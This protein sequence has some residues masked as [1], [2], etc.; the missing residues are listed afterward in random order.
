VEELARPRL[1]AL[2][3]VLVLALAAAPAAG[4]AD[5]RVDSLVR[6]DG[7]TVIRYVAGTG[8]DNEIQMRV[9]AEELDPYKRQAGIVED[10]GVDF[11]DIGADGITPL[12]PL[13]NPQGT[14]VGCDVV[15]TK[16]EIQVTLGDGDDMISPKYD[17]A[18]R[19]RAIVK[20]GPGADILSVFG[21]V[22]T[23]IDFS[24]GTGA[25]AIDYFNRPN[26]PYSFTDDGLAN[27][28]FGFDRIQRDVE[29]W[30]GG[31]GNDSF[32]FTGAGRH[33]VFGAG[34][35]DTMVSG[36][37]SD[38][39]DGGYG[40][41]P[42][43]ADARSNDAVTYAGR[44][45][46]VTVTLDGLPDDGAPGEA[47]E[48]LPTVEHVIGTAHPDTLVGPAHAPDDRPYRLD[49]GA[50]AD[51]LSGGDGADLIDAGADDDV[52]VSLGGR[53][54]AIRCGTGF[55]VLVADA[56][57]LSRD[58]EQVVHS[59]VTAAA[60]Q[61]GTAVKA[62]LAVPAPRSTVTATLTSGTSTVG[63]GKFASGAGLRQLTVP[64]NAAGR[65]ALQKAGSLPVTLKVRIASPGRKT[66]SSS[67]NVTLTQG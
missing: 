32:A 19:V 49:G 33:V 48:I 52:I 46:G 16:V 60:S 35:N 2:P 54:D 22:P 40:G 29:L 59:Y 10:T 41:D 57:D 65:S 50:G 44:A 43:G 63:S 24:G 7:T 18:R 25:D 47:D 30:V 45:A 12:G 34:G 15:G 39:L 62:A 58:C 14:G 36:P 8:Q 17:A 26:K 5:P 53:K 13:C 66:I 9:R 3:L 1:A 38:E 23:A 56:A 6:P 37:G 61:T 55:D 51:V 11:Y 4:A 67:K 21:S 27:D 28:G 64:L 20:G 42:A 31:D